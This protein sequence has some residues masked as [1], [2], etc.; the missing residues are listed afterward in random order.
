MDGHPTNQELTVIA[1]RCDVD[2]LI[3]IAIKTRTRLEV[4]LLSRFNSFTFQ[5]PLLFVGFFLCCV[6]MPPDE[7]VAQPIA[8]SVA[9]LNSTTLQQV[10][11]PQ[12]ADAK[13]SANDPDPLFPVVEHHKWGYMDKTGKVVIAPTYYGASPF[14]EGIARVQAFV[15]LE[16]RASRVQYIDKT[17]KPLPNSQMYAYAEPFSEGMALVVVAGEKNYSYIDTSGKR[18]IE[19]DRSAGPF[20]EG[21]AA[22]GHGH[23]F[24]YIDKTGQT[25]ISFKFDNNQ[26]FHEGLG[27][28]EVGKKWGFVDTTGNFVISPQYEMAI[29]FR[30]GRAPVKLNGKWGYIDTNGKMVIATQF[31]EALGFRDE[32]GQV[33]IDGKWGY[34]DK[35]GRMVIP[36]Q[37]EM[38]QSHSEGLAGVKVQ[39]KWGFVDTSGQMVVAPQFDECGSFTNGLV[40]VKVGKKFG[41][42]DKTG[43]YIWTPTD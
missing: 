36:A 32:L 41:Y 8:E 21:L 7:S 33:K 34:V 38:A 31:A 39:G 35:S 16:G 11:A 13:N 28:V 12:S 3:E 40:E 15:V 9:A 22:V 29:P 17:G 30:D 5:L 18:V 24:G 19:Q 23:Q 4:H 42:I 14:T 10:A 43:K 25:V 37:Y 27:A 2:S 20:S 6:L 1:W 26:A